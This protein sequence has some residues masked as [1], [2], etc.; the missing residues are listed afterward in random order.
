MTFSSLPVE[1]LNKIVLYLTPLII[2]P[3]I[4]LDFLMG[5]KHMKQSISKTDSCFY[6][7]SNPNAIEYLK[8]NREYI[9]TYGLHHNVNGFDLLLSEYNGDD[10]KLNFC[11][12]AVYRV[13]KSLPYI[14]QAI[15]S[16][17]Y[18]KDRILRHLVEYTPEAFEFIIPYAK[19]IDPIYFYANY[20]VALE[21]LPFLRDH[22][23][24]IDAFLYG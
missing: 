7:S 5:L 24:D 18:D 20:D 13:K 12:L 11:L 3:W 22:N 15:T 1:I 8:V 23:I 17:Y 16:N 14:K 2:K 4:P 21:A 19:D 6:L 9:D 10:T